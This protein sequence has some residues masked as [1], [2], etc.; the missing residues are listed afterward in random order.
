M[1]DR[2]AFDGVAATNIVTTITATRIA[3][4]RPGSSDTDVASARHRLW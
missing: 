3:S 4:L 1:Q 2:E